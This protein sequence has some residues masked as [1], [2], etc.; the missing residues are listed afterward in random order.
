M[1]RFE[2]KGTSIASKVFENVGY[3]PGT[4]IEIGLS[5]DAIE[6]ISEEGEDF[7]L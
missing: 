3:S 1:V 2:G 5:G 7:Q 6:A 4:T